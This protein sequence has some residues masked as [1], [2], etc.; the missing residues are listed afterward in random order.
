MKTDILEMAIDALKSQFVKLQEEVQ[1]VREELKQVQKEVK[2]VSL[3][4]AHRLE[5]K[6][7]NDILDKLLTLTEVQQHLGVSYNTL[8]NKIIKKGLLKPKR[9]S[10]R[11]IRFSQRE[12]TKYMSTLEN[13]NKGGK[14]E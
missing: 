3:D 5:E 7:D 11:K 8:Q 6:A 12:L 10:E 13:S 14:D 9:L 2:E 4:L 1:K